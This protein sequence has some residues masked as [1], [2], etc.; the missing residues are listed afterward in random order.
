MPCIKGILFPPGSYW[1]QKKAQAGDSSVGREGGISA[2]DGLAFVLEDGLAF[3][4][5]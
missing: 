5:G 2:E 1:L 4:L 3:V